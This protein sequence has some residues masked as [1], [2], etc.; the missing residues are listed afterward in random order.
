MNNVL[1]IICITIQVFNKLSSMPANGA[2]Q[3]DV[4][5]PDSKWKTEIG[6]LIEE[7]FDRKSDVIRAVGVQILIKYIGKIQR[8]CTYQIEKIESKSDTLSE[9][10]FKIAH[11]AACR[12]EDIDRDLE[13]AEQMYQKP[14]LLTYIE[15]LMVKLFSEQDDLQILV[16]KTCKTLRLT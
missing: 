13:T 12:L 1:L 6:R 3:Y 8:N 9:E 14:E 5:L 11:A 15:F 4:S 10:D 16:K 7:T 2:Q